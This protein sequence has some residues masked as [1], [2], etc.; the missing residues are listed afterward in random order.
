[1]KWI[2]SIN[3]TMKMFQ[4]KTKALIIMRMPNTMNPEPIFLLTPILEVINSVY[5]IRIS[6]IQPYLMMYG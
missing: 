1:M 2:A 4:I 6:H 5:P 3:L